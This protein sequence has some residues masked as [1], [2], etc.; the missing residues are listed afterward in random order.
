MF[1][2]TL[3]CRVAGRTISGLEVLKTNIMFCITYSYILFYIH[4]GNRVLIWMV[5]T[6]ISKLYTMIRV[7]L[8]K[9]MDSDLIT[10]D[11]TV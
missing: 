5:M 9:Q 6:G 1:A 10:I 8:I 4:V 2:T 11:E 7:Y 3:I